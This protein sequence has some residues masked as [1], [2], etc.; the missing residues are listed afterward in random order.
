MKHFSSSEW[1]DFV[2]QRISNEQRGQMERHLASGCSRC[3]DTLSVWQRVRQS[4]GA[5]A[6]YQPP[7]GALRTV[8]A[9]F[10]SVRR[11][12]THPRSVRGAIEM[13][14][15]SFA[16][17]ALA[18]ARSARANRRQVLY[19]AE[20]YQIDVQIE[21]TPSGARLMVTGQVMDS[22]H[23]DSVARDI[24]V[25]LSNGRGSM[26]RTVTNEFGEFEG[27]VE[28]SGDLELSFGG[29]S[30]E[31]VMISLRDALARSAG[32]AR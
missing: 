25:T 11:T 29:K 16:Q 12:E 17:P 19:R 5:E 30:G 3:A 15:D 31:P 13:L 14:F 9:A 6:A 28:N 23:A 26:I 22:S 20:P 7:D 18:G 27:V 4:A 24:F 8:K 1:I 32:G 21:A 10:A 2:N